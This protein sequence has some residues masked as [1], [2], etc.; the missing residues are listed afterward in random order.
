MNWNAWTHEYKEK[1][2]KLKNINHFYFYRYL[3][4][5]R[6]DDGPVMEAPHPH[7]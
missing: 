6:N 2:F 5:G 1:H 3:E 7:T 4:K